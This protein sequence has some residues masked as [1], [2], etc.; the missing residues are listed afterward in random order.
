[1]PRWS[2]RPAGRPG[3]PGAGGQGRRDQGGHR[4]RHRRRP[5]VRASAEHRQRPVGS[6]PIVVNDNVVDVVGDARR[7]GRASRPRSRLVPATAFVTMDAQVETV[8]SGEPTLEG[9]T[10]RPARFTVRGK[11]P[12]GAQ[13]AG[14]DLRGRGARR[15]RPGALHRGP[16]QARRA[17]RGRVARPRIRATACRHV[18]RSPSSPKVAEYTSPPFREYLRVILKVSHNL[19]ASTLPLLVAAHHGERP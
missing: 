11:M 16:A 1:M 15:L 17:G 9:R 7:E 12:V 19:H 2:E 18:P 3:P 14:Q 13:A 6:T 5:P 8:A 4:R 10:R